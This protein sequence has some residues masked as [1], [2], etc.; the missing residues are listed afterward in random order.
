MDY[1]RLLDNKRVFISSGARG[2]GREIALLFAKQGAT[3][4]VGGKNLPK[5]AETE[6]ELKTFSPESFSVACNL[7]SQ[8]EITNA[9]DTV[10][11]RWGGIDILVNT[12]GINHHVV[13]HEYSE[14]E[15]S[16]FLDTNYKSA[17]RLMKAF[18]PGM[19][20]NHQGNIVNISSIHSV[21]SM[22]G[23][24]IYA[25]T[26]AALNASSRVMALDYARQGI[27]VNTICPGLILSDVLQD[28]I[29]SYPAGEAR[30]EFMEM[31]DRMQPLSPGHMIDIANAALFLASDMSAYMTGQSIMVDGGASIKA[32]P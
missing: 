8:E 2:I 24:M 1:S 26:K 11:K 25:G 30:N 5:L 16:L 17:L 31:L 6:K 4:C 32:H 10:L 29:N 23:Y 27:R 19:L 15:L 9:V 28:E 14:E 12:V 7:S 13:A 22:P 18:V 21:M 20:E 3:V